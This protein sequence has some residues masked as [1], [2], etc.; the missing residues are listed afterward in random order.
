[1]RIR[2]AVSLIACVAFAFS[3]AIALC[4][5]Q[6]PAF[7][8]SFETALEKLFPG[9]TERAAADAKSGSVS[10][11]ANEYEPFQLIVSAARD[12]KSVTVV[13]SDA[14]SSS[15]A[16]IASENF[17]VNAVGYVAVIKPFYTPYYVRVPN[18]PKWPDPLIPTNRVDVKGTTIQPFWIT[19]YAPP[20]TAAGDYAAAFTVTADGERPVT[21]DFAVHVWNFT[22]PKV[23][24]LRTAFWLYPNFIREF[25]KLKIDDPV[26]DRMV[27]K[28]EYDML[29]HRMSPLEMSI[30][31]PAPVPEIVEGRDTDFA[32]WDAWMERA[33]NAGLNF[34]SLP[35][36]SDDDKKTVVLKARAW[37]RHMK[38]KGW[39]DLA[40]VFLV[41]ET[42]DGRDLRA[43]VHEG[44]PS[45]RNALTWHPVDDPTVDIWIPQIERGFAEFPE[46][47]SKARAEGK[48]LWMYSSSPT[49]GS[50]PQR[51]AFYPNTNIDFPATHPRLLPWVCWKENL[52]G[53]LYWC[54]NHWAKNPWETAETFRRQNGN[55][56][57]Y[58]PGADGPVH[59]IR[60]EAFRD[61]MEDYEYFYLLRER[62]ERDRKAGRNLDVVAHAD[63]VLSLWPNTRAFMYDVNRNPDELYRTRTAAARL[64]EQLGQ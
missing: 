62:A 35:L 51:T 5:D 13:P 53:Y 52:E 29:A 28:Y 45:L 1:M 61:G 2:L 23:S 7:R 59:S 16:K 14:V 33:V 31:R 63:A 50:E 40:C 55:G 27:E 44:D 20:G 32:A 25:Y 22:L 57:F 18:E 37:G 48:I 24:H 34:F 19:V 64:I 39:R 11:A 60:L 8:V 56:S 42:T 46:A 30:D 15:G 9:E 17:E 6:P 54:V 26:S 3:A 58:Y 36:K 10:L 38:D 41:D 49:T 12:L 4:A 43:W 47:V 21:A